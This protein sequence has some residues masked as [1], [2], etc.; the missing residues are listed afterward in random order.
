[1]INK[2][3]KTLSKSDSSILNKQEVFNFNPQNNV[4]LEKTT[5]IFLS[6]LLLSYFKKFFCFIS[7][8]IFTIT[9]EKIIIHLLYYKQSRSKGKRTGGPRIIGTMRMR[10]AN[11]S[12]KRTHQRK[13]VG[14]LH[15]S[16]NRRY[17]NRKL[18]PL[19]RRILALYQKTVFNY[20]IESESKQPTVNSE[21]P[22]NIETNS[23]LFPELTREIL[24][25]R[26]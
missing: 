22:L 8:P 7:K 5:K 17:T 4:I 19:L 9:S 26:I 6:S 11:L 1:M 12:N 2:L 21:G 18:S 14:R 23:K 13:T 15:S 20:Y 16:N 24:D 10:R 25:S 3:A